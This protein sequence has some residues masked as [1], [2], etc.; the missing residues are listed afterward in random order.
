MSHYTRRRFLKDCGLAS[1][2]V[3]IGPRELYAQ[4]LPDADNDF[5]EWTLGDASESTE[6]VLMFRGNPRRNFH[7]TGPLADNLSI[8]WQ[9]EMGQ[10]LST[11]ERTGEEVLWMGT[12]WTGQPV[13]WGN[14]LF[15]GSLD[16]HLYCFNS[17]TGEVRW[18]YAA[19]RMYKSSACFYRGRLYIG[20]VDNFVRCIDGLTG[21]LVWSYNTHT[22]IDS[23]PV[24]YGDTVYV[25]SESGHLFAF[26]PESGELVW[27]SYM[28]GL[29]G[30]LGSRG[31]ESSPAV[32][33]DDIFCGTYDGLLVCA[34]R[35][36]GDIRW[37]YATAADTDSTPVVTDQ[38]VYCCGEELNPVIHCVDRATGLE[39][40]SFWHLPGWW[41]TPAVV[42]DRLYIGGG[43]RL[44]CLDANSGEEQ[45]HFNAEGGVWSSPCVVDNKVVFGSHDENL[46]MIDADTGSE[47]WR[48][49]LGTRILS[50][51]CIV[52]GRIYVGCSGGDFFCFGPEQAETEST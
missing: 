28:G 38:Y 13:M 36:T 16:G 40:W 1:A 22:D 8:L 33:G 52:D 9:Y 21:D 11:R 12:G 39:V 2:G 5:P 27:R 24:V 32:D 6:T 25:G 49:S 17:D 10:M 26:N 48:H 4:D 50:T 15:I 35:N 45:W 51:P 19:G 34:D 42:N 14:N 30:P 47:I 43:A 29:Y 7:G 41:S 37:E 23:S 18:A 44:Y 31:I 3:V 20:N 46:Y